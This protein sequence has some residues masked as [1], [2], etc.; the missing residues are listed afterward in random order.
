PVGLLLGAVGAGILWK[1]R[2]R[3]KGL[4]WL[5]R[6]ALSILLMDALFVGVF[7][8]DSYI[9][10]YLEFYFLA[11]IAIAAGLALDRLVALLRHLGS[12]RYPVPGAAEAA[13]CLLV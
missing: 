2:S 7:Q 8:N 9:H 12:A 1:S 10:Q 6:A 11:P 3:S 4:R 5:G 13:V